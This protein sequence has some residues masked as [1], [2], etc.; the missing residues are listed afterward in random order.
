MPATDAGFQ[1]EATGSLWCRL[2]VVDTDL[3]P[4]AIL[5]ACS[6]PQG[7]LEFDQDG[8]RDDWPEMD[9]SADTPGDPWD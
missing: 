9:Q 1:Q 8:G 7:E 6:P 5:P 2:Q 4:P 3:E